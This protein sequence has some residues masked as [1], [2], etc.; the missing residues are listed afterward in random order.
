[1]PSHSQI[2]AKTLVRNGNAE[3]SQA[4]DGEHEISENSTRKIKNAVKAN[5]L[6]LKKVASSRL[7]K[8]KTIKKT[9]VQ[10]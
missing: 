2:A 7:G 5:P 6:K 3:Q 4:E 1:M 10:D 9:S 8:T